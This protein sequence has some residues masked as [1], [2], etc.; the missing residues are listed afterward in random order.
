MSLTSGK[1][2]VNIRQYKDKVTFLSKSL[3]KSEASIGCSKAQI[4]DAKA[5][6]RKINGELRQTQDSAKSSLLNEELS[7]LKIQ[8]ETD[9]FNMREQEKMCKSL[10]SEINILAQRIEF[11]ERKTKEC[12]AYATEKLHEKL[13]ESSSAASSEFCQN[14]S[15]IDN[16]PKLEKITLDGGLVLENKGLR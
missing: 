14:Y 3:K 8:L 4:K 6:L 15:L 9:S 16:C 1:G 7:A 5:R 10:R 13:H 12:R 11:I 2:T